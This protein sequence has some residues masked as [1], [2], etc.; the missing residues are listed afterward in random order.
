MRKDTLTRRSLLGAGTAIACSAA[1]SP[2]VTPV[3]FAAV[4]GENRLVVIVLRGAMDGLDVVRP[5]SDRAYASLRPTIPG[6]AEPHGLDVMF[7]LHPRLGELM[8]LWQAG[9]LAFAHAVSTPYRSKRSHFDGQDLLE[10]GGGAANGGLTPSR[11]GWLNRA[12]AEMPGATARTAFAVGRDSP[13]ILQG[14]SP[15][16]SWAPNSDPGLTEGAWDLLDILYASDPLFLAASRTAREFAEGDTGSGGGR[17]RAGAF[18]RFAAEQLRGETR[19]AAFSIG[20]W[21]T[22][23]NQPGAINRPLGELSAALLTLK[24]ELGPVWGRTAV[25]CITE[26]GR[27]VRENGSR[28]T[29]HGTGG[30]AVMAGGALSGARVHGTWP[31]LGERDLFENRDLMPTDDVRRYAGWFLRDMFGLEASAVEARIFPGLDMGV[32]PRL[33]A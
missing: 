27:T 11:D 10:N 8:P 30:L 12:I 23:R 31:G 6:D 19:I 4:P 9:E 5:V 16:S 3:T 29:D 32:T 7:A 14:A 22:H 17:A 18:A 33:T 13:L 21:D 28:G 20:G 24:R 2:F 1:A 25:I 26:F 15:S